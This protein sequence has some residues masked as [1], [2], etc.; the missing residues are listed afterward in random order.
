MKQACQLDE[1]GYYVCQVAAAESP[2]EPGVF[3]VPRGAVMCDQP[4]LA[5]G[6]RYKRTADVWSEEDLPAPEAAPVPPS[7]KEIRRGEI[8]ARLAAIDGASARPVR[9]IAAALADGR[10]APAFA[11]A[12]LVTIELEAATLRAEL[13]AL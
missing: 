9:E 13:A 1:D 7:A 10:L 8:V 12:K 4:A 3:L 6:K 5:E 2:L 11:K